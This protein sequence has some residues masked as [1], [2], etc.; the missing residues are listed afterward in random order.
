LLGSGGVSG[1]ESMTVRWWSRP[2][3]R[4]VALL[5]AVV[6]AA[7]SRAETPF[8]VAMSL[9]DIPRT[10]GGPDGG[11]EGL[12]MGGYTIYDALVNWDLR[13]SDKP[14][15]L[16]P[17]LAESWQ[18]D[19]ADHKRW[20]LKLRQGVS[21]HDGSRFDA[22]A[23]IWNFQSVF[24][25]KA[26]QYNAQR[27][28]FIRV[29]LS[30]ITGYEK[31]DDR[32]IAVI[33]ASPNSLTIY[34]L[35][36]LLFVSPAQYA[37]LGGDWAKFSAEPSGTGPFK[38]AAVV[39]RERL[40]LVRNETYWDKTRIPKSAALTLIPLPDPGTRVA[41]LRSG[42]VDFIES[43]PPDALASLKEAGF[44]VYTNPYPHVW[45]WYFSFLPDS[46]F[47]DLRVR[48]AA[49]LAIDRDGMVQ[50]LAGTA[51]P[52]K[53][54]MAE[55]SPWFGNPSFKIRF[56]QAEAKKLLAEAGYSSS[57]HVK[58][59]ILISN[60]GGGQ[61]QPLSMNEFIQANL[62]DV[63]I[64]VDYEIVDFITLFTNYRNGA[65]PLAARGIM[66]INL[67][68]PTQDP[69]TAFL[70]V[71]AS[72]RVAPRGANWGNYASP[73]VDAA[74]SEV[75][76]AFEPAAFDQAL[77]KVHSLLIDDAPGLFVV[78]DLNP[79]AV[80]KRVKGFIAPQNWFV[81]FTTV[82]VD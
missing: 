33:T 14:S 32:T 52:A 55:S 31:I 56:D 62:A 72:D 9:A 64:D 27:G 42:Q 60:S 11:F 59:K 17:G 8:R 3:V 19:P 24:D 50:L 26:P 49:N 10:W 73:A 22:D 34:Q 82:S 38:V 65:K 76:L 43:V 70:Q 74:L 21:F 41:A 78:H 23:A 66:G 77:A 4:V 36:F 28:A 6:A 37:K 15:K 63:G 12:R 2:A 69:T 54:L 57:K 68:L 29:R 39:P 1:E 5:L 58:A 7:P 71:F 51:V 20:I 53:G 40:E 75:Q 45:M 46:P 13:V 79:R 48:K 81:D 35:A 44:T 18:L 30:S 67:A 25:E 80:A 61:M 16:V 47:L